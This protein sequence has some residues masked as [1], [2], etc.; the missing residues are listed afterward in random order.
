MAT[1]LFVDGRNFGKNHGASFAVIMSGDGKHRHHWERSFDC[2]DVTTNQ[3]CFHGILFVL[4][5]VKKER[6]KDEV[7]LCFK[8]KYIHSLL[9]KDGEKWKRESRTNLDLVNGV[10]K[11]I[12]EYPNIKL[13]VDSDSPFSAKVIDFASDAAKKKKYVDARN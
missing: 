2:E 13:L 9:E 8:N 12:S 4:H 6:R 3:A 7:E 1:Q 10:R 11:I 5:S